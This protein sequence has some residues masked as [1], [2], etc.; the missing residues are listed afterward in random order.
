ME[1]G[2]FSVG[3]AVKDLEASRAFDERL[4]FASVAGE[5]AQHRPIVRNGAHVIGLFEGLFE[6]NTPTSDPGWRADAS[7]LDRFPDIRERQRRPQADGVVFATEFDDT[8]TGPASFVIEDP[9][10]NPILVGPHV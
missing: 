10:G 7:P 5:P 4:G 1:L 2:A 8:G 3:L 6:K 9:D